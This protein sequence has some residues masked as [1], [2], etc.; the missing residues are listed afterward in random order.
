MAVWTTKQVRTFLDRVS[1]ERFHPVYF[2]ALTTGM[3]RGELL[4]L[5]W[6]DIDLERGILPIRQ[7]WLDSL[8]LP[9]LQSGAEANSKV[10]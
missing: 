9:G 4:G 6:S 7:L 8:T 1:G 3:R 2:V 10:H 5:R